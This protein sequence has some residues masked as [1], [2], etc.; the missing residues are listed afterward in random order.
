MPEYQVPQFIEHETKIVGPLTFRQ[1]IYIG[2]GGAILFILF[3]TVGEKN[4]VLFFIAAALIGGLALALAFVKV[5]GRS[6]GAAL[7]SMIGFF[8]SPRVFIWQKAHRK[9]PII[10]PLPAAPQTTAED[11]ARSPLT[12]AERSRLK[13]LSWKVETKINKQPGE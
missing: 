3:F 11:T 5:G 9:I 4:F 13:S 6:F 1:F 7:F 10:P 12:F 8:S 2:G